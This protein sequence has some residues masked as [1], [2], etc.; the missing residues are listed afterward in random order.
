MIQVTQ[1]QRATPTAQDLL[2]L[3]PHAMTENVHATHMTPCG[4]L[5]CVSPVGTFRSIKVVDPR[6]GLRLRPSLRRLAATLA[7]RAAIMCARQPSSGYH[8][9]RAFLR[10]GST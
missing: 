9:Q 4:I 2:Y 8:F 10:K 1:T 6:D 5:L 3:G 7:V